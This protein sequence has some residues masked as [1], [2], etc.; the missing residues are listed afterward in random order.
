MIGAPFP[1]RSQSYGRGLEDLVF[2]DSGI[3]R[4]DGTTGRLWY[5]GYPIEQ[6][7]RKTSFEEVSY[8]ILRGELPDATALDAW[9]RELASWRELPSSVH[10]AATHLPPEFDLAGGF[11]TVVAAAA[12]AAPVRDRSSS[13]ASWH[14]PARILTWTAGIAAALIRRRSDQAPVEARNDLGHAAN[15]LWQVFGREPDP[16]AA[17]AFDV[18]LIVQAEHGIHAAALAALVVTSTR[19]DLDS[20]VV[21]G[22]G[23]LSGDLHGNAS[24]PAFDM[25]ALPE[26]IEDARRWART[27]LAARH[28]FAGYGHR[29]Y[30][31][32]DPRARLLAPHAQAL[33]ERTGR[34]ALWHKFSAIRDE[35]ERALGPKGVYANVDAV[36]GLIYHALGL[37]TEA[38]TIPFGLAIQTGWMAHCLEYLPDGRVIEPGAVYVGDV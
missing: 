3:C 18:S 22:F 27:R 25:V 29:V 20:A 33:L 16:E 23:A 21:A 34:E 10:Q 14:C 9:R 19:A 5:R 37:P 17:R 38:F 36:T 11:G 13:E 12:G 6:L 8:L 7:A 32:P 28:R 15:F 31:S 4:I 1:P 30:K 2:G 35:V 24:Q 26:T